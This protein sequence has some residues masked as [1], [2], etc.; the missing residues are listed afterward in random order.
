MED[1]TRV[2]TGDPVAQ[3]AEVISEVNLP[4]RLDAGE[5]ASHVAT[6]VEGFSCT[7]P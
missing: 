6:L 7:E 3:R 5:H 4:R 1:V 2:L